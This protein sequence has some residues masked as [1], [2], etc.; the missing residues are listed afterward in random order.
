MEN[1]DI[2]QKLETEVRKKAED[3]ATWKKES[4]KQQQHV[5]SLE[6]KIAQLHSMLEA[7]EQLL[8]QY[9]D[10]EKKFEEQITE[11]TRTDRAKHFLGS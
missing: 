4:E 5:D 1:K 8:L 2:F 9:K 11:V 10:G 7:K 3:I 6:K